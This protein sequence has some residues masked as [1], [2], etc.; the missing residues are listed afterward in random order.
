MPPWAERRPNREIRVQ[1][2]ADADPHLSD[3]QGA[4]PGAVQGAGEDGG[5][6]THGEGGL[7]KLKKKKLGKGQVQNE[8]F[9]R[10]AIYRSYTD[11]VSIYELTEILFHLIEF[12]CIL[13]WQ[14]VYAMF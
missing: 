12:L 1:L 3:V 2:Q 5:T 8:T 11:I 14:R 13:T 4:P 7:G 9:I 6:G 10:N